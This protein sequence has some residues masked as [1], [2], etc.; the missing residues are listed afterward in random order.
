MDFPFGS[1]VV[2]AHAH[3]TEDEQRV[4]DAMRKV[5]P[6]SVEIGRYNMKGHHGNLIVSFEARVTQRK[7]I[8]ELWQIVLSGLNAGDLER[9]KSKVGDRVDD[10]RNFYLRFDKQKANGGELALMETGDAIHLRLKI[11]AFPATR[12]VAIESVGK[13]L[14]GQVKHEAE[15][16]V[17]GA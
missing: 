16:Q 1:A 13:F 12:E 3:A 15:A 9:L 4:L 7:E 17:P 5:L 11:L 6:K 10:E 2:S 8:K 14:E